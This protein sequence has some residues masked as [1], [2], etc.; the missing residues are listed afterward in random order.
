MLHCCD[1]L[2][3]GVLKKYSERIAKKEH[4]LNHLFE[5]YNT[6]EIK[7]LFGD[8]QK[9]INEAK[10]FILDGKIVFRLPYSTDKLPDNS[11]I[12]IYSGHESEKFFHD[13]GDTQFIKKQSTVKQTVNIVAVDLNKSTLSSKTCV[14][15]GTII[16]NDYNSSWQAVVVDIIDYGENTS[17]PAQYKLLLD[18]N[19]PLKN[20]QPLIGG[21]YISRPDKYT[22]QRI[23]RSV[24]DVNVTL[25]LTTV[26]SFQVHYILNQ[27]FRYLIKTS[28]QLLS[29]RGM[30]EMTL[31]YTEIHDAAYEQGS[32][33]RF[34]TQYHLSGKAHDT[35]IFDEKETPEH[36]MLDV[37]VVEDLNKEP[38]NSVKTVEEQKISGTKDAG[39]FVEVK[40]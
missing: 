24:D 39:L 21:Y 26:G 23:H 10:Q 38:E 7:E 1:L 11:L 32:L 36:I 8:S 40:R 31:T 27:Y 14:P 2:V 25:L 9:Y 22:Q 15:R 4:I 6:P 34:K 30:Q 13:Y 12:A 17:K 37:D 19:I 16:K 3:L 29:G 20:K 35:W 5:T 18:D 33:P 28:R